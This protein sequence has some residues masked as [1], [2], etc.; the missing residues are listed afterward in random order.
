MEVVR[1]VPEFLASYLDFVLEF[2]RRPMEAVKSNTTITAEGQ[3]LISGKLI[4]FSA[5]SVG[6]GIAIVQIGSA[7][8]MA[9]DPSLLLKVLSRIEEKLLPFAAVVAI[10]ALGCIAHVSLYIGA[11]VSRAL[12][13]QRFSGSA[14]GSINATTA[15]ST[16]VIPVFT[17]LIVGFRV[18]AAHSGVHTLAFLLI[19]GPF[20]IAFFIYLVAAFAAAH[21]TTPGQIGSVFGFTVVLFVL[22]GKLFE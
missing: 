2:S 22:V 6:F 19:V 1:A 14:S 21:R 11:L 17:A 3:Q 18:A 4:G 13:E 9:E 20:C 15:F 10:T 5:M 16:W 7:L 8:G 12:G